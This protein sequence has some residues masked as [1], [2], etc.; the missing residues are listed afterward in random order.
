MKPEDKAL[1]QKFWKWHKTRVSRSDSIFDLD[2]YEL[3]E[4]LLKI[5]ENHANQNVI[6]RKRFEDENTR[7]LIRNKELMEENLKLMEEQTKLLELM[8]RINQENQRLTNEY[9]NSKTEK[10]VTKE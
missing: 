8:L 10:G 4:D 9:V 6:W 7:L 1:I 5:S 3:V 2:Y